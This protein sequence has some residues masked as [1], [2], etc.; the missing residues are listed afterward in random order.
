MAGS[1]LTVKVLREAFRTIEAFR[2]YYETDGIDT[3]V[4]SEG[5]EVCLWDLEYLLSQLWR[6]P[7]RQRQA[8]ELCLVQNM[9]ESDAALTMGVSV[10][11]PVAMYATSGLIKIVDWV[12]SGE[13]PRYS[14]GTPLPLEDK[15]AV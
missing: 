4:S 5:T 1:S 2:A 7:D 3:V 10:T 9:K 13:L 8:I 11:N 14:E 15:E 12:N 6:L